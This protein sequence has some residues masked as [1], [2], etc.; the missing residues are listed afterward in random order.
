MKAKN[1]DHKKEKGKRK[2]VV[3]VFSNYYYE[4]ICAGPKDSGQE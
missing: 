3:F 1:V 2:P 4:F